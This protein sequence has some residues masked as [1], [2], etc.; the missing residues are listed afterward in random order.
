[1]NESEFIE[2]HDEGYP[3]P[4]VDAS[5]RNSR[6]QRKHPVSEGQ[7]SYLK[8]AKTCPQCG[9]AAQLTWFY[10]ESPKET[11]ENLCGRAG[12]MTVCDKCHVQVDFFLEVM[13]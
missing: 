7:A 11:W 4:D 13:N 5:R 1:V 8:R 3:W 2:D 9:L 6:L 12:W 10:F